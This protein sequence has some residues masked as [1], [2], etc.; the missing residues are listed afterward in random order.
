VINAISLMH[1]SV[2]WKHSIIGKLCNKLRTIC[3]S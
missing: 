3:W 2:K 1:E